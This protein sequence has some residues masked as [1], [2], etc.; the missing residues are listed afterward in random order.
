MANVTGQDRDTKALS[1]RQPWAWLIREG[2]KDV[3]NRSWSTNYRGRFWIHASGAEVDPETWARGSKLLADHLWPAVR[4]DYSYVD[5]GKREF[6]KD[7]RATIPGPGEFMRGGIIG[8]VRLVDVVRQHD[9][10]W[11]EGDY[12]FV[13]EEPSEVEFTRCRGQLYFFTPDFTTSEITATQEELF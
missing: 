9:S 2:Y 12:G 8:T 4:A 6:L 11:F 7:V 1:I 3:E 5:Q 13:L 10:L